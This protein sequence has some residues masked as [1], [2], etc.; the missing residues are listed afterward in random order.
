M[1][2]PERRKTI[3]LIVIFS[4]LVNVVAWI[5][6]LL[7]GSPASPGPGFILWGT[8]PLLVALLMRMV[9]RDWSDLGIKPAI[10]KNA[11]WYIVSF[12]AL[13]VLMALA[14]LVGVLFSVSSLSGFSMVPFLQTTLTALPIFFVFAIFEEVG[15]RGYLAP[16]L[17]SLGINRY[18]AAALVAVVWASWHLPYFRELAWVYSSEDLATFIPRFYLACFA[19]SILYGEIRGITATFWPAVLMH[20]VGNAFGHPLSADYITFTA[21]KEYLG[22]VGN[23]LILIALVGLLGVAINRWRSRQSARSG[24]PA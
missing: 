2:D 6:P 20:C 14:L 7:G 17:A 4:V 18:A 5:G 16:K 10:A 22:S 3:W 8:A 9:T 1:N 15:W 19:F 12:L 24:A 21:G 13:P 11:W 23:G